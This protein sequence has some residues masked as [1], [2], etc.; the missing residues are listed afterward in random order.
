MC[1]TAP[2]DHEPFVTANPFFDNGI[3]ELEINGC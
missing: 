1:L 3:Q 2:I